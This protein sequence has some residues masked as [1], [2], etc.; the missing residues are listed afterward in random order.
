[1][2]LILDEHVEGL[3]RCPCGPG[4]VRA[5]AGT[6]RRRPGTGCSRP[7][8]SARSAAPSWSGCCRRGACQSRPRRLRCRTVVR[9][10]VAV[11]PA[12]NLPIVSP[13]RRC[14]A[15]SARR[16][17][18][19]A[20]WRSP[21][22]SGLEPG[23]AAS[24]VLVVGLL[25]LVWLAARSRRIDDG[26]WVTIAREIE[27]EYG[28]ASSDRGCWRAIIR[29]CSSRGACGPPKVLIPAT[30]VARGPTI[31]SASCFATSWRTSGAAT[32]SCSCR[33]TAA[34]RLLVQPARSGLRA[35]ACAPRASRRAT[36]KCSAGGVQA[37]DYATHLLEVARALRVDAAPRLP[38]P[39][40]ARSSRLERRFDAMLNTRVTRT[41][42]TGCVSAFDDRRSAP[43]CA[44]VFLPPRRAAPSTLSGTVTD[45]TGAPVPGD[46]RAHEHDDR[47]QARGQDQRARTVC[48]SCRCPPTATPSKR[49]SRV[50]E[51]TKRRSACPGASVRRDFALALGTLS[52]TVT[53][54][55]GRRCRPLARI[56]GKPAPGVRRGRPRP[57]PRSSATSPHASR[58]PGGRVRPPRKIK[59][60]R[61][62]YPP[63]LQ[64][65]GIGGTVDH[66]ATIGYGRDGQGLRDTEVGASR[67]RCGGGRGGR[68]SGSST[69]R[70]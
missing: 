35:R 63:A 43:A 59:D 7:P 62:V 64:A 6:A 20:H 40:M 5:A 3:A 56:G 57:H 25:R 19:V 45:S 36:T 27:R 39:A 31:G 65:A 22:A 49:A 26:P 34:R 55:G 4:G 61:P 47:G 24:R 23:D 44:T 29:P 46:G 13:F 52:E 32:G 42:A 68:S 69:A 14:R 33:R 58:R 9:T 10:S 50:Q 51:E 41:P 11:V 38:A 67:A 30:A 8:S 66:E 12:A 48:S 21:H 18:F 1:M 2:S 15:D 54:G 37:S 28:S 53:I 17:Q 60:V 16:G 70:C